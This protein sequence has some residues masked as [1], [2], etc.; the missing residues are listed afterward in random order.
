MTMGEKRNHKVDLQIFL[1]RIMEHISQKKYSTRNGTLKKAKVWRRNE[2]QR[3]FF[4]PT[5]KIYG[6]KKVQANQGIKI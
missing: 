6:W 4:F 2:G 3:V 1:H 5:G